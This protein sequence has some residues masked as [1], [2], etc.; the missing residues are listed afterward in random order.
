MSAVYAQIA[1]SDQ[2]RQR[3]IFMWGSTLQIFLA[4]GC[5]NGFD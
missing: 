1:R 5:E 3:L 2:V 4:R